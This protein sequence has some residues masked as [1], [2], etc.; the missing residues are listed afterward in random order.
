[1][2]NVVVL[3]HP[4]GPSSEKNTP[5]SIVSV[6]SLTAAV[7]P[8]RLLTNALEYDPAALLRHAGECRPV[9]APFDRLTTG[10]QT[11]DRRGVLAAGAAFAVSATRVG[12]A[13]ARPDAGTLHYYNWIDYVNPET[14]VAFTKATGIAVRKSYYSSNEALLARLRRGA[15]GIDLAAPTGYMVATLAE[16]GLLQRIDWKRLPAVRQA[17]DPTFL[18]LPYDPDGKWSVPKDWGTTGFVYRTDRIRERPTTW[19]QFFSLFEKYPRKLTLLDGAAE[20]IG[21]VAVMMGYSFNTDV[22]GELERVRKFLLALRPF[23]RAFDSKGYAT[24]IA[25]TK[26]FGGMAWNGDGAYVIAHSPGQAADYVVP[27]EGGELWVDA[28]VIPKRAT[29]R[30]AAHAW[31]DF[32]YKPRISAMESLYTYFGSPV[33]RSLL[34]PILAPVVLRNPDV[35]PPAA[36]FKRLEA[37]NLTSKGEAARNRIWAEVKAGR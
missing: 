36:T 16:K 22:D 15:K 26:A 6:T 11:Y 1:M 14:Y 31:I 37:R 19:A 30:A 20:V 33:R 12:S 29:N 18:G 4:L 25:A 21:S 3:P 17:I 34:A 8:K 28:H 5:S 9:V 27:K 2:R 35:F 32:V 13:L 23:V 7:L 24:Q 10:G